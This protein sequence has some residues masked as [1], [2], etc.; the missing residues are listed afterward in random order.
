MQK[1]SKNQFRRIG[2][3]HATCQR[4]HGAGSKIEAR[5]V[6]WPACAVFLDA[7]IRHRRFIANSDNEGKARDGA[8]RGLMLSR[9]P[10][11]STRS[12]LTGTPVLLPEQVS[13]SPRKRLVGAFRDWR[14]RIQSRRELAGLSGLDLKDL[15]YP[16]GVETE[17]E[18]PVWRR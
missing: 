6:C 13:Q 14:R 2:E 9:E 11:M 7:V 17:K 15:G 1:D 12:V 16:A 5:F 3:W 8:A 18:K 4:R 10:A